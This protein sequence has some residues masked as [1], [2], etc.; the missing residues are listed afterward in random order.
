MRP[1]S[2]RG[3]AYAGAMRSTRTHEHATR[4]FRTSMPGID[5]FPFDVW[6]RLEARRWRRPHHHLGYCDAAGFAPLRELLSVYLRASRAVNCSADQ[7]IITAGSQQAC[8]S[9]RSKGKAR[10]PSP[11]RCWDRASIMRSKSRAIP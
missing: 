8:R 5:L 3:V 7:I 11:P 10:F 4:A 6:S 2:A 9:R 1:L